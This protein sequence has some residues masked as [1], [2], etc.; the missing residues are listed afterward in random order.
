MQN[1]NSPSPSFTICWGNA[2][3]INMRNVGT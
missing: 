1:E 2:S 3:P